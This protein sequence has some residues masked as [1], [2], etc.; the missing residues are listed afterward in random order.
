MADVSQERFGLTYK[1]L[2]RVNWS[3]EAAGLRFVFPYW[4]TPTIKLICY[5]IIGTTVLVGAPLEADR[6][7]PGRRTGPEYEQEAHQSIDQ[8]ALNV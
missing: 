7:R 2:R 8:G 6:E 3:K 1:S 5:W 4:S